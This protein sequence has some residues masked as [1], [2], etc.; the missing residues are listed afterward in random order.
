MMLHRGKQVMVVGAFLLMGVAG[1]AVAGGT[2]E[3]V[4][5][6]TDGIAIAG[7]DP[8]AYFTLGEA[9]EG[10]PQYSFEWDNAEWHFVSTEHRD[11]FADDPQ[12]YAPHYGGY[13]AYAASQSQVQPA[14]PQLWT[15]H[16]GR[17]FLNLN[18][19]FQDQ[20]RADIDT[21]I[22]EADRNWPAL[23]AGLEN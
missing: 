11:M 23:R 5:N 22:Q 6:T 15:I 10:D 1:F 16:N 8:V 3:G 14:D 12:R 9:T 18:Q 2:P 20:F 7:Y 19:D 4:V 21:N 13:C 17:L